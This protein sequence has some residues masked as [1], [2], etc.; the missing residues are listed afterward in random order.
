MKQHGLNQPARAPRKT[1]TASAKLIEKTPTQELKAA[2]TKRSRKIAADDAKP[3]KPFR[4]KKRKAAEM[5]DDET[6]KSG[7]EKAPITHQKARKTPARKTPAKKMP[8]RETPVRNTAV[9]KTSFR[10]A[11]K[12]KEE[13]EQEYVDNK[14]HAKRVAKEETELDEYYHNYLMANGYTKTIRLPDQDIVDPDIITDPSHPQYD[15]RQTWGTSERYAFVPKK[16][17]GVMTYTLPPPLPPQNQSVVQQASNK[18]HVSRETDPIVQ[19]SN[20][21]DISE[22]YRIVDQIDDADLYDESSNEDRMQI[23]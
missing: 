13:P 1:A 17:N 10:K 16:I 22:P 19:L 11:V 2:S 14:A 5:E 15:F 4:G 8:V 12:H 9:R 23:D 7:D 3:S 21:E 6:A 20:D 18:T